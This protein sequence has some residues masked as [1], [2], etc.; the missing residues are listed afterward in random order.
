MDM[1]QLRQC[2]VWAGIENLQ[3]IK[4]EIPSVIK[5]SILLKVHSCAICG[6][7][8]RLYRDGHPRVTPPQIIGH[9]VAGEIIALGENVNQFNL[10]DRVSIGA[11]V[12]CGDCEYCDTGT[13]NCCDINYAIGYQFEG[14]F[15]EYLLL[16][17]LMVEQG[18]IQRFGLDT[19]YDAA[20]LAEPLACCINGYEQ[21]LIQAGHTVVIFGAGPIGIMLALLAPVFD[22]GQVIMIDVNESRLDQ[23]QQFQSMHIIH[24]PK[25]DPIKRVLEL[26]HNRGADLIFTACAAVETHEIALA[27]IA[28]KG[29]INFFGGVPKN[30]PAISLFSN[31]IHYKQIYITGSHG[32]TP[33]QHKQA[34]HLIE[35]KQIDVEPLITHKY[36]LMNIESAFQKALSGEGLKIMVNPNV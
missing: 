4:T 1:K 3:I 14:G 32:S 15:S 35:S 5:G 30:A 23:A 2:I 18:P 36:N 29:V 11:D 34:L 27:M 12:P 22:V 6:S 21:G 10:G 13:P 26:T 17:P 31:F 19:S 7:D 9:E 8:L 33:R 16:H 20:A 24:S 28:K 25:R